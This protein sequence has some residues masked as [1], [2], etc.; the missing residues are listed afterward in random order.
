[1]SYAPKG[2][3][4]SDL[5]TANLVESKNYGKIII[6]ETSVNLTEVFFNFTI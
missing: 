4:S 3:Y 6:T 5:G 2:V 1:M